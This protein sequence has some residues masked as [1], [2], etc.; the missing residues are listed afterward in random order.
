MRD[1]CK[2]EEKKEGNKLEVKIQ[3]GKIKQISIYEIIPLH[4]LIKFFLFQLCF[5]HPK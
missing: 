3:T 4:F 1:T 5:D 2:G